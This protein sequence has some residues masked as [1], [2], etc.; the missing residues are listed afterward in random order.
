M[1][2]YIVVRVSKCLKP[3]DEGGVTQSTRWLAYDQTACL[4]Y[5]TDKE[6]NN[7]VFKDYQQAWDLLV[8]LGDIYLVIIPVAPDIEGDVYYED[9]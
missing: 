7:K 3:K 4:W 9:A 6:S 5:L 1:N 8:H 2:G